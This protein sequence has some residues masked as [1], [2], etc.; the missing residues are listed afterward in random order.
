MVRQAPV[1][2]DFRGPSQIASGQALIRVMADSESIPSKFMFLSEFGHMLQ[3]ISSRDATGA[4]MKTRQVLLDM[5][6]KSG[7]GSSIQ[8]SAY[9][10]K[11]NNT[12]VVYNPNLA[13]MGD[14]TPQMLFANMNDKLIAE[15]FLPRFLY[16]EYDGPRTARNLS[17]SRIPAEDLVT[18]CITLTH[19]I[20]SLKQANQC[21]NITISPEAQLVLDNLSDW[22]DYQIEELKGQAMAEMWNRV[23]LMTLRLAGI[24][25]VGNNM[26]EPTV[27]LEDAEWAQD[28][29]LR[30][31]KTI[32]LRAAEGQLSDS[33]AGLRQFVRSVAIDYYKNDVSGT[34]ARRH[35]GRYKIYKEHNLITF[36]YLSEKTEKEPMFLNTASTQS[37]LLAKTITALVKEGFLLEIDMHKL[38]NFD[39]R[40]RTTESVYCPGSTFDTKTYDENDEED[41]DNE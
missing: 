26:F 13:L 9:A 28:I 24:V 25:A 17:P 27:T 7:W 18:R 35:R 36:K 19:Q 15:G 23:H 21:M 11:T 10:D 33:E 29:I 38:G 22:S 3:I 8:E 4:D 20:M 1:I 37:V 2:S 41:V 16:V 40:I 30:S 6:S 5:F 31:L 12:K 32:A 14:T 34:L 39:G